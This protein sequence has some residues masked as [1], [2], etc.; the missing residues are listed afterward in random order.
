MFHRSS[1]SESFSDNLGKNDQNKISSQQNVSNLEGSLSDLDS[2]I[3][4]ISDEIS[5]KPWNPFEEPV[6][7]DGHFEAAFEEIRNRDGIYFIYCFF[8]FINERR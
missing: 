2:E 7:E 5:N 6:A 3:R 1:L 4:L 8:L